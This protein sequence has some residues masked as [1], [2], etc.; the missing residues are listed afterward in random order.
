MIGVVNHVT[1]S[2]TPTLTLAFSMTLAS[3]PLQRK[4]SL[5]RMRT[6]TS[7]ELTEL[8]TGWTNRVCT[9][10]R[11]GGGGEGEGGGE[12]REREREHYVHVNKG[13]RGGKRTYMYP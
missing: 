13:E 3:L 4:R 7:P 12:G 2:A 5:S 9:L 10:L 6:K 1:G 8:A 11:P